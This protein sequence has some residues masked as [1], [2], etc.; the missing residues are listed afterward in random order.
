MPINNVFC[1]RIH[2]YWHTCGCCRFL[3]SH[4]QQGTALASPW[5]GLPPTRVVY[6][7]NSNTHGHTHTHTHTGNIQIKFLLAQHRTSKH[8]CT[9]AVVP[10]TA[11]RFQLYHEPSTLQSLCQVRKSDMYT[12]LMYAVCVHACI[13]RDGQ[14]SLHYIDIQSNDRAN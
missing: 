10:P 4:V 11:H 12:Y 9:L 14:S 1:P 8:T 2:T 13:T 5:I 7:T 3:L 6:I